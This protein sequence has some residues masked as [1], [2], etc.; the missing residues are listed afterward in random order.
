MVGSRTRPLAHRVRCLS[1]EIA[2]RRGIPWGNLVKGNH[3]A[4]P[5]S[6]KAWILGLV[7]LA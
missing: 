7:D 4:P 6:T 1:R 2:H 3:L 5:G